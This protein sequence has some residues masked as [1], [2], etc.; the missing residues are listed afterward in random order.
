MFDCGPFYIHPFIP[1]DINRSLIISWRRAIGHGRGYFPVSLS[2][3]AGIVEAT[4]VI[5]DNL[6]SEGTKSDAAPPEVC[7]AL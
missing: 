2:R 5:G 7:C 4:D 1:R 6:S 3:R